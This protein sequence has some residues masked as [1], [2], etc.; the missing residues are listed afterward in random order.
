MLNRGLYVTQS[1][2]VDQNVLRE[3]MNFSKRI[4]LVNL[5]D[6]NDATDNHNREVYFI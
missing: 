2:K 1:L 5:A 3:S 6:M 4:Y